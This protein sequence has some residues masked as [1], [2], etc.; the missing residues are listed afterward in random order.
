M[1]RNSASYILIL[2]ILCLFFVLVFNI[3]FIS[4]FNYFAF[5][6]IF[7]QLVTKLG[8]EIPIKELTSFV[9]ILQMIIA[10]L[11]TYQI[12]NNEIGFKMDIDEDLYIN[13]VTPL[14]FAF[15]IGI[16]L[17]LS[18]KKPDINILFSETNQNKLITYGWSFLLVGL[19]FNFTVRFFPLS[20]KFIFTIISYFQF[21][22]AFC[23]FFSKYKY[24]NIVVGVVYG[25]FLLQSIG[26][27]MFYGL[28]VWGFFLMAMFFIRYK[29]SFQVK[30]T[31][32]LMAFA[33]I[34]IIQAVKKE[35]R[36][37]LGKEKEVNKVELFYSSINEKLEAAPITEDKQATE[38]FIERLNTG[39]ITAKVFKH[40]PTKQPFS[41]GAEL[42]DDVISTLLP[43]FLFPNKK[44]VGGE[45]NS[46]K[47]FKYTGR[48]LNDETIMR[49]GIIGDA[50]LNFG[51]LGGAALLFT[52][53]LLINLLLV[54]ITSKS[55]RF[56]IMILWIPIV[57]VYVVRMSDFI[58]LINSIVKILFVLILILI[59][60]PNWLLFEKKEY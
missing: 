18:K 1:S 50:Y 15:I 27:G 2:A 37:V 9:L 25:I 12:Y 10:P 20:L 4:A 52:F 53:G 22:G 38:R 28:I 59:F 30:L 23:L 11:I 31:L 21:L 26:T 42:L 6:F 13:K 41:Y 57:F 45:D 44:S 56:P 51:V 58:V 47:F 33:S 29:T 46:S 49:V 35:F 54:W 60:F 36:E 39:H 14:V 19:F 17:P 40:T 43:R 48:V 55:F 3:S 7:F 8:S 5:T 34:F 24:R 32:I 16:Y